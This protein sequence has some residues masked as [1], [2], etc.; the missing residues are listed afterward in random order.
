MSVKSVPEH[1]FNSRATITNIKLFDKSIAY[2]N[3]FQADFLQFSDEYCGGNCNRHHSLYASQAKIGHNVEPG[4]GYGYHTK[5]ASL[6]PL[7]KVHPITSRKALC[8]G[9]HAF[10]IPGMED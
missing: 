7:V 4:S 8:I 2:R 1:S 3:G 5:G 6:R 10:R 9:R